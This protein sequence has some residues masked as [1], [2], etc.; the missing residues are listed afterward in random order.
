MSTPG[1][2]PAAAERELPPVAPLADSAAKPATETRP[3]IL[4]GAAFVG[5]MILAKLVGRL[6][7]T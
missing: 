5:G 1:T 3:E 7:G 6:R 2:D 4:V